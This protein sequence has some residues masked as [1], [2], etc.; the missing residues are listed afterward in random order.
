MQWV[1]CCTTLRVGLAF[2]TR[3]RRG[4]NNEQTQFPHLL[5]LRLSVRLSM[6]LQT[7]ARQSGLPTRVH[8]H[9]LR[10]S[11]ASHLLQS[12]DKLRAVPDRSRAGQ[13]MRDLRRC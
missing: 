10:H 2:C 13:R 11:D 3:R 6:R 5:R 9:T 4:L 7:M 12:S 8:P 1:E